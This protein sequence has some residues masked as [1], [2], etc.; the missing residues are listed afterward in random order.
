MSPLE[1]YFADNPGTEDE[2]NAMTEYE[3]YQFYASNV[4]RQAQVQFTE[5]GGDLD[6]PTAGLV[7][8]RATIR[9]MLEASIEAVFVENCTN[10]TWYENPPDET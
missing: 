7:T 1:Q 10:V 3:Q 5:G 6:T 9:H 4:A 8:D 2:Y